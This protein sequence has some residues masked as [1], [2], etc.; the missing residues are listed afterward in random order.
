MSFTQPA[1]HLSSPR[2]SVSCH[3]VPACRLLCPC[4]LRRCLA[5]GPWASYDYGSL[6][7]C[8]L[9]DTHLS[10]KRVHEENSL[11]GQES[12]QNPKKSQTASPASRAGKR[13]PRAAPGSQGGNSW[14]MSLGCGH[15]EMGPRHLPTFCHPV[16]ESAPQEKWIC[17][18]LWDPPVGEGKKGPCRRL[19]QDPRKGG[20]SSSPEGTQVLLPKQGEGMPGSLYLPRG[21]TKSPRSDTCKHLATRAV[22]VKTQLSSLLQPLFTSGHSAARDSKRF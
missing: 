22:W 7:L 4:S 6:T 5:P 18:A 16:Q 10:R 14:T 1:G 19:L 3:R 2:Q 8:T 13:N 9:H 11:Y 20:K 21:M 15:Q 12:F 17:S